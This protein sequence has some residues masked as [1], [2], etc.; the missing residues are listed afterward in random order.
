MGMAPGVRWVLD[1]HERTSSTFHTTHSP[2][3]RSMSSGKAAL[4]NH[5]E[6]S[7]LD[8]RSRPEEMAARAKECG[9]E[10]V[11]ITDHDDVGGHFRFQKACQAAGVKPV[12]GAE[13]RWMLNIADSRERKTGAS[14]SS[15]I[16]LLAENNTGLRNLWALSSLAY[17]PEQFYKK[18][19]LD[20]GLLMQYRDGLWASDGCMLTR[21]AD[22]VVNDQEDLAR[23]E[24]GVLLHIFGDHFYSELHTWQFINPV[25]PEQQALNARMSKIN[26]AKVRLAKEMGVPLVVVNDAHYAHERQWQEHRA[27][28][29][30][31]T[32]SWKKDQHEERGHAADWMMNADE[33]RHYMGLHGVGTSVIEEAMRNSGWIADQCNAEIDGKLLAMPRLHATDAE[34]AAAFRRAIEEGFKRFVVDKGLPEDVYR[35]RLEYEA[36]LIIDKNM[37]GYF[38]VV[39]DYVLAARNGTYH[40][41]ITGDPKPKPCL[42]GPGRGSAGGSLVTYVMGITSIDPIKYDL[43]FERFINPD[44]PDF[45]DI[46]VDFQKSKKGLVKQYLGKRY[47]DNNVVSIGTRTHSRPRQMLQD[48]CR[49]QGIPFGEMKKMIDLVEQV[50]QIAP[51]E[52]GMELPEDEDPP[53]WGEVLQ[54]IGGE[55]APYAKKYPDLFNLME[56]M[57]N[58]VRGVGVHPAGVLV[59]TDPVFPGLIPTRRKGGA[60][61]RATQFDMYELEELGGVK[62]DLL[63]NKGLDVLDI[64]R[65]LIYERHGVWIDY[66]GFGFGIPEGAEKVITLNEERYLNDPAI[67]DQID[68]GQT[69]GL[70]QVNTPAGTKLAM[71]FKPRSVVD[72][73]D[74]A[75]INR[76]GVTRVPGLLDKY[77]ERRHGREQVTYDH[78]L[79]GSITGPSSSMNTYGILV[80]QEQLIRTAKELAGF[81]PG[82]AERLRKGIGK[83]KMEIINELEPKFLD[84]CMAN[85]E[86]V[87]QGGTRKVADRIWQSL[88]AAGAY[89]FNKSHGVGYALQPCQEAWV[90]HYYFDEFITGC[91]VIHTDKTIRFLR[92]CRQRKRAVLPPDVNQSGAGFTLTDEGIRFGLTD[93]SGIGDAAMPDILANRPFK[94]LDDFLARASKS[95]GAKKGVVDALIK[96]GAFDFTGEHRQVMLEKVYRHRRG[97]SA[98]VKWAKMSLDEQVAEIAAKRRVKPE[99]YPVYNFEDPQFIHDLEVEMLGTFVSYDPMAKY[100]RMIDGECIRHPMDY[101]DFEPGDRFCVGGKLVKARTHRQ[102]N[103]KQMAFLAVHWNEEDFEILAFADAW[104][105]CQPLLKVGMPVVCEVIKLGGGG[106]SLST[107]ERLDTIV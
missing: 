57:V 68:R 42:C 47:G 69:A 59:N 1:I 74:L 66:D 89:A 54:E 6:T 65:D 24:W 10:S 61:I 81:T 18:P 35:Q 56:Q 94:D 78:P 33:I 104:A 92:E 82:E 70:F 86:F 49:A 101:D 67:Y 83:K 102:K 29:D 27:I 85:P 16:V 39:A 41:A 17:E 40:Q 46:D 48:L 12:L 87:N 84:G 62:D 4:H 2:T 58:M 26:L 100:A 75:S 45:P 30:M 38:N 60:D 43:M 28:W 22:Y 23:Q 55:L 96:V 76:P 64:A 103:G 72:M 8:G 73:A 52:E 71:R 79:M 32:G 31:S 34:D 99:D 80:Y 51:F 53:T 5:G 90:K 91:L 63:A 7:I 15:H 97:L 13:Q 19:Q 93:I 77:I 107:V 9:D 37:A 98:P 3:R 21:F 88:K 36:K 106:A 20:P 14:D 44:R 25:S 11:A 105:R 95:G 50:D